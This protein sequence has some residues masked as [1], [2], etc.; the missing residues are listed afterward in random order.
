MLA[1]EMLHL[2]WLRAQSCKLGCRCAI[3]Y[4]AAILMVALPSMQLSRRKS[5]RTGVILRALLILDQELK[6]SYALDA[7]RHFIQDDGVN[8]VIIKI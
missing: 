2:M 6:Q 4:Y 3:R 8:T 1:M 5:I 7:Y